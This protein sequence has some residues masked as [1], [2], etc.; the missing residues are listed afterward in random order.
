MEPPGGSL[1][2]RLVL[3]GS[4]SRLSPMKPR[5]GNSGKPII[6]PIISICPKRNVRFPNLKPTTTAISLRLPLPVLERI[7]VEANKRDV[8]YQ[9]LI[10]MWP[11]EKAT[12]V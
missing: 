1:A 9:P 10:R 11:M 12:G 4:L 8:P 2:Q 3:A 7:K 6:R 5:S